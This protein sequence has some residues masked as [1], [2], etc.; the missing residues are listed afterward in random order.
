VSAKV[1]RNNAS[2]APHS[3]HVYHVSSTTAAL[4]GRLPGASVCPAIGVIGVLGT[5]YTRLNTLAMFTQAFELRV[6]HVMVY[7]YFIR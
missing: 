3:D 7:T 6:T 1:P 5:P 2:G 4:A